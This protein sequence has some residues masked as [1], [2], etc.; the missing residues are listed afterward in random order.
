MANERRNN[1]LVKPYLKWAGGKRQILPEIREHLPQ[2]FRG[3]YYHE[4]FLGAGALFLNQQPRR[5][6]VNDNNAELVLTYKV[7][8]E[9]VDDL[10]GVL[11]VHKERNNEKYYYEIREQDRD[12]EV[13]NKLTDVQKAARL[14]YLNKTCFNGLYRVNSQGLFNVPYGKYTNPAICDVPV[15]RAIHNYL[16]NAEIEILHGDFADAVKN[17]G[18]KTFIY[19]DPPYYSPNN[20]NFTGY[21]AGGFGDDEQARLR[22]V[23]VERTDAGAKCLL[24]N[25]DTQFIRDLYDD[26]RFEFFTIKA[27][28]IINSDSTGRGEV[29][30]ILIKNWR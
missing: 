18:R 7:I 13:F 6:V 9:Q 5:A 19:F 24:S 8:R 3:L 29:D 1:P 22:D 12:R 10:I 21:L 28:R 14:I 20:T 15:L 25:S 11:S 4:P 30:E 17:A 16:E 26:G 27:K 23:F 2:N